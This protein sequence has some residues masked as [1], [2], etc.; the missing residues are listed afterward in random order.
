MSVCIGN[1]CYD[2][3]TKNATVYYIKCSQTVDNNNESE[4]TNAAEFVFD[5]V[6]HKYGVDEM[7]KRST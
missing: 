2:K 4:L 6:K 7:I 1:N 5:I 3:I